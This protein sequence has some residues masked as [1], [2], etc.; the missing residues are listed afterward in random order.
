M[1]NI[2]EEAFLQPKDEKENGEAGTATT[3]S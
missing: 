2:T 1:S 3:H